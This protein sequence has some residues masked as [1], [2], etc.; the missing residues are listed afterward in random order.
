MSGPAQ[1][2]SSSRDDRDGTWPGSCLVAR[3]MTAPRC[4]RAGTTWFVTRRTTRRHF[5]LRPDENRELQELYWY[6]TGV[7]AAETGVELH[8]VQVLSTHI[9]EVLT[10]TRGELPR[11][12]QQRN[13]L[14]ANAIKCHRGWPEEVFA[15]APASCVALYGAAAVE[16]EIGYTLANCVEAGLVARPEDWPGVTITREGLGRAVIRVARPSAYF[17]PNNPRWPAEVV[18]RVTLPRGPREDLWLTERRSESPDTFGRCSHLHGARRGRAGWPL[19]RRSGRSGA[20]P[21]PPPSLHSR[22]VRRAIP[23]LCCRRPPRSRARGPTRAQDLPVEVPEGLGCPAPSRGHFTVPLRCVAHLRR[24][25]R[26]SRGCPNLRGGRQQNSAQQNSTS[27]GSGVD[28][29]ADAAPAGCAGQATHTAGRIDRRPNN[30]RRSY[31]ESPTAGRCPR[32]SP[33]TQHP[34]AILTVNEPTLS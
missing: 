30:I 33:A 26:G 19:R 9:H 17:D 28:V 24:V 34:S 1:T 31:G 10:D 5:L 8:A 15:R 12:L 11:F 16:K 18:L 23:H 21:V 3:T 25:R 27:V 22:A 7:I 32:V 13:R 14:L 6:T 2:L 20:R 29:G 4:I